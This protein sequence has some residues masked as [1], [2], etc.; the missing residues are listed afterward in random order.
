MIYEQ[1]SSRDQIP[2]IPKI[3]G[4]Y[5][6]ECCI[7]KGGYSWVFQGKN[8]K[9][10]ERCAL[11]VVDRKILQDTILLEN[12]EKELRIYSR[13]SHPGIS[14]YI[15]TIYL[16]DYIIIVQ[17]LLTGGTIA[18]TISFR[19]RFFSEGIILRWAKELFE[20]MAYL[21][22]QNISHCDIKPDN[23]GY[24]KN[25]RL[26]LFDF[27]LC[28][29]QLR[30]KPF[31]GGTPLFSAPEVFIN[32]PYDEFKADIWSLGVTIHCMATGAFPFK[33]SSPEVYVNNM[34]DPNFI[35]IKCTG[36]FKQIVEM[37]LRVDPDERFSAKEVL[38]TNV[39]DGAEELQIAVNKSPI[40]Y[41]ANSLIAPRRKPSYGRCSQVICIPKAKTISPLL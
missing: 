6:V 25:T 33:S 8:T 7:G 37:A 9:T 23:I 11:K 15:D 30:K 13:I 36:K 34:F 1:I 27:G 39:F 3:V 32:Q 14:K 21:H 17:E 40:K 24:D 5:K 10:N 35:D 38:E 20:T 19:E 2:Q 26:K 12:F 4:P 22:G 41:K 31:Q 18:S 29:D 28:S 16:K